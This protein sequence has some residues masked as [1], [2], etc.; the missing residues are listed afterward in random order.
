M[1]LPAFRAFLR[2]NN[3]TDDEGMDLLQN[4]GLVSDNAI[5]LTDCAE[6]DLREAM[7]RRDWTLTD[8]QETP[9]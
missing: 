9:H 6:S 5:H 7:K 1:T 4:A 3:L 8:A 2:A